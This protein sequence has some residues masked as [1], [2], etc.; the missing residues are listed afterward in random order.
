MSNNFIELTKVLIDRKILAEGMTISAKVSTT[1]FG[2]AVMSTV[3]QGIVTKVSPDG[4]TAL[5]EDKKQRKTPY[6]NI[7]AIEG[8]EI[9]R[10]AQAYRIKVKGKKA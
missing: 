4:L 2:H 5:F 3:K 6:E 10:F 8:M 9:A 1:G 7:V